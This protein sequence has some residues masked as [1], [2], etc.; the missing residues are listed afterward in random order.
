MNW[1]NWEQLSFPSSSQCLSY[2]LED[3]A[4]MNPSFPS[5]K[6]S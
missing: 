4:L 1:D 5:I 3:N 2:K 6:D